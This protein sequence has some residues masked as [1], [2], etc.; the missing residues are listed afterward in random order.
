MVMDLKL[1]QQAGFPPLNKQIQIAKALS[2]FSYFPL[3]ICCCYII[4][5]LKPGLDKIIPLKKEKAG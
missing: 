1:L 5:H 2:F 3:E 4:A